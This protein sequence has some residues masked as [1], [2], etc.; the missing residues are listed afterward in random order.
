MEPESELVQEAQQFYGF[1]NGFPLDCFVVRSDVD[2]NRTI[3][4]VSTAVKRIVM[5]SN[6]RKLKIVN[7]GIKVFSRHTSVGTKGDGF[8]YRMN[9]EGLQTL[10]PFLSKE[11]ILGVS[12]EDLI[13]FL[14][15]Q[16]PKCELFSN[17]CKEQLLKLPMGSYLIAFYPEKEPNYNGNIKIPILLPLWKA[18]VSA[19]VLLTQQER[20][21][22]IIR[23]TG[24]ELEF[25]KGLSK[26][27]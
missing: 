10:A 13:I 3:Y 9:F 23:L 8:Q 19:S 6:S 21:S 1:K 14:N 12:F 18:A 22:L 4:F 11:M 17:E 7:T 15:H 24:K 25:Q 5:A 26:E 2:I 16:Y 20:S 27:E